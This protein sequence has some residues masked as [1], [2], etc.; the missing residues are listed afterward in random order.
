VPEAANQAE[1]L[2]TRGQYLGR[3]ADYE[4][5]TAIADALVQEAPTEGRVFILRAR[6]QLTWHR[7]AEALADLDIA[8]RLGAQGARTDGVRAGVF[9]AM[10][11]YDEALVL[12]R[13]IVATGPDILSLG[14]EGAVF[15]DRGDLAEAAATFA[16]A[17]E[18]YR[19]VSPF[20]VAWLRFQEGAMW[21]RDGDIERARPLLQEAVDRLPAYA[22]ASGLLAQLDAAAG[23]REA[24]ITRLTPLAEA[25]DDPDYAAQLAR[26]LGEAGRPEEAA[27]W[28][29]RAEARFT[30]LV[31]VHSEAFADHAADFWLNA[32]ADAQRAVALARENAAR[33]P[34]ARAYE[35]LLQAALAIND[36]TL[37]CEAADG[38]SRAPYR[39][40]RLQTLV[41]NAYRACGRYPR[42]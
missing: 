36:A 1:M 2:L 17:E 21:L 15:A 23:R 33:R 25:S 11:R 40:P 35:L 16:A 7:F 14:A 41:T 13:R 42:T 12:H 19:D 31:A 26:I 27:T 5:A 24:A 9:K 22:S 30:E 3:V 37:G 4:R 34:T 32:G 28:R 29:A 18:S 8:E 38:A 20:P 39:W 6:V 10:G